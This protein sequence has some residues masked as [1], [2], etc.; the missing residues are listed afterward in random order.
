M[1]HEKTPNKVRDFYVRIAI[2]LIFA[3]IGYILPET[4]DVKLKIITAYVG[5]SWFWGLVLLYP[6][7][8]GSIQSKESSLLRAYS[9]FH[10]GIF[11]ICQSMLFGVLGGGIYR[12]V[13]ELY[14][15]CKE[16][17]KKQV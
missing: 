1:C 15:L 12:F 17:K 10:Y 8:I 16:R 5:W 9:Y 3:F 14:N 2:S 6:S 7:Y 11:Y 4:E 13:K